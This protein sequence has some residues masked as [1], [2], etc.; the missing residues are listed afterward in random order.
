MYVAFLTGSIAS[1]KSYVGSTLHD[2]YGIERIDLDAISRDVLNE[3]SE[4]IQA[5]ADA[6]GSDVLQKD[7]TINRQALAQKAFVSDA[8]IAKLEAIE[9]PYIKRRMKD[10]IDILSHKGCKV[11]F[12]EVPVLDRFEDSFN[13]ADE[14]VCVLSD[15][16]LRLNR[17]VEQRGMNQDDFIARD[18]KQP[19][20]SYL[21]DKADVIIENNSSIDELNDKIAQ[22]ANHLQHI[23]N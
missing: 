19:T 18:S 2:L 13:I 3:D 14:I 16:D 17:A 1:G 5:V 21:N 6:F 9:L 7:G 20:Q 10:Q 12:I 11:C 8:S 4:C 15:Y 22:L 23:A